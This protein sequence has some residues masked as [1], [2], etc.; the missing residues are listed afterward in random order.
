MNAL[1][2]S[3]SNSWMTPTNILES[4]HVVLGDI[5]LDP[6]SSEIADARVLSNGY[7]TERDD[8]LSR[9]WHGRVF[10]NPPGGKRGKESLTGLFWQ[11]LM[12]ECIAG[13]VSHAIFLSF[14]L[15]ALSMT[16]KYHQVTM[17]SFPL[18]VPYSRL[19]FVPEDGSKA[20]SPTHGNVIV[21]VPGN[22]DRTAVFK[23]EFS[24]YGAV[25]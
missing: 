22:I 16:Q 3:K 2:L 15:E 9:P 6:A 12:N 1:H 21:Y 11:K 13:R 5:D 7:F 8:G 4:V 10:I 23:E 19:R 18:C 25:R 20:Q 14:S 24:K 17:L